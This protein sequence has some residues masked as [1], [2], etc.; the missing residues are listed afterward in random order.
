MMRA[1]VAIIGA[2]PAAAAFAP[3]R[4]RRRGV[5]GAR[6]PQPRVCRSADPRRRPGD[7]NGGKFLLR[8]AWTGGRGSKDSSTAGPTCSGPRSGITSTL[9]SMFDATPSRARL[10]QTAFP[11]VRACLRLARRMR[12]SSPRGLAPNPFPN[13]QTEVQAHPQV[14]V[15]ACEAI[16]RTL[17]ERRERGQPRPKL[18]PRYPGPEGVTN[19]RGMTSQW[20]QRSAGIV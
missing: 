6:D 18:R 5:G 14:F 4:G 17:A 20:C 13:P 15:Y 11:Q 10:I 19:W 9:F 8:A 16:L 1:Q 12:D 2:G 3:A 7:F